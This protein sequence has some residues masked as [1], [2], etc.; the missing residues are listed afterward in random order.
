VSNVLFQLINDNDESNIF[1]SNELSVLYTIT[2][3]KMN[4]EFKFKFISEYFSNLKWKKIIL[5]LSK[6]QMIKLLFE[7]NNDD[8]LYRTDHV[9]IE[10]VYE[11]KR[12]CISSNII[13]NILQMTHFNNKHSEF[14][15]CYDEI[16]VFWYIHK[17][18]KILREFLRHC[19][20]CQI[21]QTRRHKSY[22]FLQSIFTSSVFFHT[23]TIDFILALSNT[24]EY[25]IVMF[26][27]C[28]FSKRLIL[29]FENIIWKAKQ[30]VVI[31][32][33]RLELMNWELSKIIISDRDLKFLVELWST[34]FERLEI[35]FLYFIVYHSQSDDQSKRTNQSIEIALRYHLINMKNLKEWSQCISTF[36][37]HLNNT[38]TSTNKISNEILYEFISI[39]F[40]NIIDKSDLFFIDNVARTRK[41]VI[42]IG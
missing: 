27:T 13:Q 7:L 19:F 4:F 38:I 42:N 28:K 1:E 6:N 41:K 16:F 23:I 36:Q 33:S 39:N 31:L 32:F 9:A 8:L 2:F 10:H 24:E 12:L 11:F 40:E 22:D 3:V 18:F 15:K 20:E 35:K 26:V 5:M 29:I 21:F 17:L 34:I 30:W 14:A 25:D 37:S